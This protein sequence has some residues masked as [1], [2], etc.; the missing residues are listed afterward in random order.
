MNFK[1]NIELSADNVSEIDR[2]IRHLMNARQSAIREMRL[3]EPSRLQAEPV[4]ESKASTE[5]P[6]GNPFEE[7]KDGI[8]SA[9]QVDAIAKH[10]GASSN[11]HIRRITDLNVKGKTLHLL[12]KH[13]GVREKDDFVKCVGV[14][15]NECLAGGIAII[16]KAYQCNNETYVCYED[17]GGTFRTAQFSRVHEE[18]LLTAHMVDNIIHDEANSVGIVGKHHLDYDNNMRNRRQ[19]PRDIPAEA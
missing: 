2:A 3:N 9:D 10:M 7:P 13:G 16:G 11:G 6:K 4:V 15:I 5:T 8:V 18:K 1:I 12:R 19:L 14:I 17:F